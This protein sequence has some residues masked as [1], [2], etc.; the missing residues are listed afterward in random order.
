MR[1]VICENL[2]YPQEAAAN[3]IEGSVNIRYGV[4]YRGRVAHT[5]ILQG[6]GYGCDEEAIRVVKLLKFVVP[7]NPRKMKVAFH[8]SIRIHF[9]LP[10]VKKVARK[11]T[12]S[13]TAVSY[14]YTMITKKKE[15]SAPST[16]KSGYTYT[17]KY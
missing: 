6:L 7:K 14:R 3:K 17:I 4:D 5:N 13:S 16:K 9:K 8:K 15:Q 10:K 1:K 2:K 11:D 12:P